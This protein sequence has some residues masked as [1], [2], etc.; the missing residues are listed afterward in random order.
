MYGSTLGYNATVSCHVTPHLI[1]VTPRLCTTHQ[2][3]RAKMCVVL[4][5]GAALEAL[6]AGRDKVGFIAWHGLWRPW[7]RG[8]EGM[9][10]G[11]ENS[12]WCIGLRTAS[13]GVGG[14]GGHWGGA[15]GPGVGWGGGKG[16]G[17]GVLVVGNVRNT[18]RAANTH[19]PRTLIHMHRC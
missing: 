4:V 7:W 2:S 17:R 19:T 18:E 5:T 3:P 14:R 13:S 10:V 1:P 15:G 8:G 6:R 16:R 9:V 12:V 11:V